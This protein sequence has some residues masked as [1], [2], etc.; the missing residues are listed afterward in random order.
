[1]RRAVAVAAL[2]LLAGG[3]A[4][5]LHRPG[6]P[7]GLVPAPGTYDVR[8]LRD[9]WG[10]PHVFG[11]TDADV[12]YGLAWAHAED[13][14]ET[15]QGSLAAARGRLAA[16][17]GREMAPNDYM[18]QLLE[19]GEAVAAGYPRLSSEVR[20][21]CEAYAAGLDHYAAHHPDRALVDLYPVRGEDL[22]AGFV[23]KV[24]LFF[25]IDK[26]LQGLFADD[27]VAAVPD[28]RA[29]RKRSGTL[30]PVRGSNAF[31]VG[32]SRTADGGTFLVI[33]SHQ[34]WEGPVAWYEA[35]LKSEQGWDAVGGVFPGSPVILH[36]H[37]RHLG[38]AHTVNRPDLIDVYD[39]EV[40][41]EDPD[42]YR[43]DREWRDLEV[44][45]VPIEV[46]LWG[47]LRWTFRR[48]VA[49]S[50]HGPVV[51]R[52]HGTYAIRYA[53]AGE[54]G[55]IEQWFRMNKARSFDEWQAAMRQQTL[56]MFNTAYADRAGNVFYVYNGRLP[57]RAEGYD[58]SGHL[59]GATSETLWSESWTYDQL[60]RVE[61]PSSGFVQT[62]NSSPFSTTLGAG[63]PSPSDYP[64]SLGIETALTNRALRALELFGEDEE[65]TLAELDA[66]KYDT[67]YSTGS[68]MAQL[69]A[70]VLALP[71][72]RDP[73]VREAV[74]ALAS[75]DLETDLD[76]PRTALAVLAL[77]RFLPITG[78]VPAPTDDELLTALAEAAATLRQ[79]HGGLLVPWGD[80][81]R[82]RHGDVDLPI[83]GGPDVLHAVYGELGDD[84]RIVGH[85]GD[86]Y[87]LR[88]AW[89]AAGE[90]TSHSIHQFGSATR[91][92]SSSHY[93]DQSELFVRRQMKPV[94]MDEA[95]IRAHLEREY[96]P[97]EA[98]DR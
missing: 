15:L 83:A 27:G 56:P 51:R 94:W 87:V 66:I 88:V 86:S 92:E 14:F 1:M 54:V 10:V 76:N 62:C 72:P 32:P 48:E 61:N 89:D 17:Y 50:V 44:R 37:N 69:V 2:L 19:V 60:P 68:R 6:L 5:V 41:P 57:R 9:T 42:R 79:H 47:P 24:P 95:E 8:I 59:P 39:L 43:F 84:G 78:E 38:W 30:G 33:N 71:E 34:P 23:H 98:V 64:A 31:A 29:A 91:D 3:A 55:H 28:R 22:V 25:G 67:A 90:L 26:V 81:Q 13:D 73:A 96:R 49:K 74:S 12:A 70:R 93:A 35:H 7:E 58:W 52:P 80:V 82:L 18:V 11:R 63:N 4:V 53:G 65:I 97:G 45:S 75:W 77:G 36:G 16:A 21:V 40:D 20:A 85:A 46:R